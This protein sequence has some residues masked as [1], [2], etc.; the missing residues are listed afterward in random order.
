VQ[1]NGTQNT[2]L[3]PLDIIHSTVISKSGIAVE[4]IGSIYSVAFEPMLSERRVYVFDE[5]AVKEAT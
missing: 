2:T 1:L 3:S 5:T 4:N